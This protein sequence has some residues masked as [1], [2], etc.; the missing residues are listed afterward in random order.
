M[1]TKIYYCEWDRA[2]ASHDLLRQTVSRF[3]GRE[4]EAFTVCRREE[5]GKPFVKELPEVHFSISHSGEFWACAISNAEVGLDLQTCYQGDSE[6][7]AR[8]FFHPSE[9]AWLEEHGFE[10][11]SRMWA[12]KESYV[13]YTGIGLREGLDG[14]SVVDGLPAVQKEI[15]FR[16]G[17]RMV[18]TGERDMEVEMQ[19]L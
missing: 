10:E 12:Y 7:L 9:V 17:Y 18:L 5:H 11:F 15:P 3:L 13:K 6:K 19:M 4:S 16:F 2:V 8:R 14:F 1:K